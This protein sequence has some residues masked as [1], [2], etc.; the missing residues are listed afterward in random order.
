MLYSYK[1]QEPTQIPFRIRL[2]NGT[3]R[4]DPSTFT[5][6]ELLDAG[7][8]K[9]DDKP[10]CNIKQVVYWS[11]DD[12]KWIVRDKNRDEI[13][14]DLHLVIEYKETLLTQVQYKIDVYD[15][16]ILLNI[17]NTDIKE[18][19]VTYRDSLLNLEI[20]DPYSV[21]WPV[22]GIPGVFVSSIQMLIQ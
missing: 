22:Y 5:E 18:D 19:L 14:R 15:H 1:N 2:S 13:D 6:E 8:I 3:T 9:I 7:Y 4:S 12:V 16:N 21:L 20:T 11:L 10:Q 17:S